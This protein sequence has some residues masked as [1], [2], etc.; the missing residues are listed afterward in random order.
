MRINGGTGQTAQFARNQN[1]FSA[2]SPGDR[3]RVVTA[4]WCVSGNRDIED[5]RAMFRADLIAASVLVKAAVTRVVQM[6]TDCNG[7]MLQGT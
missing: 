4:T 6:N 1:G 5:Y 3:A 7:S 2:E